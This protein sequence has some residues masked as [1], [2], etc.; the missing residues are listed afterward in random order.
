MRDL[1]FIWVRDS[2]SVKT[3]VILLRNN[4]QWGFACGIRSHD[5]SVLCCA[6]VLNGLSKPL[7]WQPTCNCLCL[8]G[9]LEFSAA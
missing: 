2:S 5:Q 7:Y 8:E 1:D 3:L 9:I 6:F 4:A